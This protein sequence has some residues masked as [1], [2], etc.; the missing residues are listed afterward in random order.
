MKQYYYSVFY[1]DAVT[2]EDRIELLPLQARRELSDVLNHDSIIGKDWRSVAEV[3]EMGNS[4]YKNIEKENEKMKHIF[5]WMQHNA[6]LI[7]HLFKIF[8]QIESKVCIRI[9][10]ESGITG[11]PEGK[12]N[13]SLFFLK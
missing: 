9:L 13:A 8:L 10:A 7:G 12:H 3:L 11:I 6:M 1:V 4:V 2:L 5:K